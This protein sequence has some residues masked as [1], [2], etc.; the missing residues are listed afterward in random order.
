MKNTIY[1]YWLCQILGWGGWSLLNLFFVFLFTQ[2]YYMKVEERRNLFLMGLLI[3]FVWY[4][5]STHL[6]RI[7]LKKMKWIYFS[8]NKVIIFFVTGVVITGVVSYYGARITAVSTGNSI[9]QYEKKQDLKSA[10]EKEKSKGVEGTNYFLAT[11]DN[12]KD[13]ANY[14]LVQKIKQNTGWY[15]DAKGVWKYEDPRK[16][17]FW[18]NLIFNFILIALWLLIYMVWH[19]LERNRKDEIDK[20]NLLTV[21]KE[22]E[23]KTIKSHI[24]PHFIFNSLNSI[25]ALVDEN[26]N[27]ARKAITELSNI[28]RSSLQVEKVE[29]VTLKNELD[30]VKD[31]LAIEQMR[32]EERLKIEFEID[33]EMH[34]QLVPPMMLQTLVENAIKHGISKRIN[35]GLVKIIARRNQEKLELIVQNSGKLNGNYKD[36]FGFKSTRDRLKILYGEKAHFSVQDTGEDMVESKLILPII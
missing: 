32:F 24:N 16:G 18:W 23:L 22:M 8:L 34:D 13:S 7:G 26:P 9:I 11:K 28:L 19:Y 33:T 12:P 35:G 30:I 14:N 4:I 1:R 25:R 36:G 15:R 2:D 17:R 10:I 3:Q 31:Y 29:T 20:L 6:L 21:V 27:R 5:L